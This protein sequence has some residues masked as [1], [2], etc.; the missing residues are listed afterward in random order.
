MVG[1]YGIGQLIGDVALATGILSLEIGEPTRG[2][3]AGLFERLKVLD[4]S[5]V[6]QLFEVL[7]LFRRER[8]V[9]TVFVKDE[10]AGLRVPLEW[11]EGGVVPLRE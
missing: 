11:M 6:P 1:C 8:V 4:F 5:L 10:L 7:E 9:R 3:D 2:D